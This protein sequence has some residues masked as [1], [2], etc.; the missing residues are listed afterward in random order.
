M[1]YVVVNIYTNYSSLSGHIAV[2]EAGCLKIYPGGG[3]WLSIGDGPSALKFKERPGSTEYSRKITVRVPLKM[4][5]I[6]DP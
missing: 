1:E 2:S 5:S 4:K 6:L 3:G